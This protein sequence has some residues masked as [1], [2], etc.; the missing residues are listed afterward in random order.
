MIGGC[1]LRSWVVGACGWHEECRAADA[2]G[3]AFVVSLA[4][5]SGS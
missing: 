5:R 4:W 3:R 2:C 1:E